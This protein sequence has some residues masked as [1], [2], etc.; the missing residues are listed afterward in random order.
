MPGPNTFTTEFFQT[1]KEKKNK[2]KNKKHK[3]HTNSERTEK[4]K[5]FS[6]YSYEASINLMLKSDMT[7]T[8]KGKLLLS[9]SHENDQ[10]LAFFFP[11]GKGPFFF[12][13]FFWQRA[14]F[15]FFFFLVNILSFVDHT[16]SLQLFN[17]S[18]Y[19]GKS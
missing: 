8:K 11:L 3:H 18:I 6:T 15:F 7:I 13:F 12:F 1:F 14:I 2:T 16:V 19:S 5:E 10:I 17:S 9:L 4:V